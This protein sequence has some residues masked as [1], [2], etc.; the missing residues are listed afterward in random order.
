MTKTPHTASSPPEPRE[1]DVRLFPVLT[2]E[3]LSRASRHGSG[4]SC[5]LGDVLLDAGAQTLSIFVVMRGRV[6]IVRLAC[7]EEQIV[8]RL[9]P[10]QFTG[11]VGTLAGQPALV[12]IRAAAPSDVIEINRD[13]LLKIVQN[14]SELS[15][16]LMRAFL[17]RRSEMVAQ[18]FG[19]ALL[20]G[21]HHSP[22]MLR[23]REFLTRNDHPYSIIDID[24]D[25]D[26]QAV[27]DYFGVTVDVTPVLVCREKFVL[28]NPT[29][30]E[31]ADCLGF[32]AAVH[33]HDVRDLVIVGA[34]P[35]GLAAAVYGAS[36]GL[37]VLVLESSAPGG[38]AGS[39][40]KIENYLGFPAGISGHDLASSALAQARKF[41][42]QIMV[43]Q[44]ASRLNCE[45]RP[46]GI[47][48]DASSEIRGRA[49]IIATGAQYRKLSIEDPGRFD[50]TRVYYS[51]TPMEAALCRDEEVIVVGGG[52]AA[53]QAAVFLAQVVRRVHMLVRSDTLA[54]SM[55]RYLIRRIEQHDAID[56]RV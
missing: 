11:E 18:H 5:D 9:A 7:D 22:D 45:R 41:G 34:G 46:F 42:A 15:D 56:L 24:H 48:L 49:V 53:G 47:A 21:S 20:V 54:E 13:Q 26:A 19:D 28:R 1:G 8:A 55:S 12:S 14:D 29:N 27:L 37:D 38:Q 6:D 36:E 44:S 25:R 39:S 2:P 52:N 43:A 4:R 50:G 51:A 32:N 17:Q 30:R 31:I 10:G 16:V 23:M 33:T 40:S 35:S 3:Q